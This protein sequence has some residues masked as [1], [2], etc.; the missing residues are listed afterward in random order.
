MLIAINRGYGKSDYV[1][2]I[3]W[4]RNA[5]FAETLEV[6]THL[7]VWGRIQSR[8]YLK[9]YEDGTEEIRTAYEISVKRLEV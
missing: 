8:E 4:G 9:R 3:L 7:E 1:P 6:G 5:R 2:C